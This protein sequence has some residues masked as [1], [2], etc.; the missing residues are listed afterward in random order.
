MP[1]YEM[2]GAGD[3]APVFSPAGKHFGGRPV[4]HEAATSELTLNDEF[5]CGR[6][7]AGNW[8]CGG[9]AHFDDLDSNGAPAVVFDVLI[10]ATTFK[11][12]LTEAQAGGTVLVLAEPVLVTEE[13]E[14]KLKVATAPATA[15]AG[16]IAFVPW[17]VGN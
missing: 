13:T 17:V 6:V 14:V 10:G 1:E 11:A 3:K 8:F 15:Q 5:V 12:G 9:I 4:T 7:A 16:T 2:N